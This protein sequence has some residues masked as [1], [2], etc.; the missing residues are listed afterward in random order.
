MGFNRL[1][2]QEKGENRRDERER[3]LREK[4]TQTPSE[5]LPEPLSSHTQGDADAQEPLLSR[6]CLAFFLFTKCN[7]N[8]CVTKEPTFPPFS[9]FNRLDSS[10]R[11][12]SP[13]HL[14]VPRPLQ[15]LRLTPRH[16]TASQAALAALEDRDDGFRETARETDLLAFCP[17]VRG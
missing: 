7:C 13:T 11:H 4:T 8:A 2:Q 16:S 15:L 6:H 9:P 10:Q 12:R 14:L 5:P 17:A 3:G 1:L